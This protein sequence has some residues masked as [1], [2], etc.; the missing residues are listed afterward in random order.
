MKAGIGVDSRASQRHT[1]V[2]C[3]HGRDTPDLLDR[4]QMLR[5]CARADFVEKH[6]EVVEPG[7]R[8]G[9]D[10]AGRDSVDMN[11]ASRE[12]GCQITHARF[13][14]GLDRTH[15]VVIVDRPFGA[16]ESH[17]HQAAAVVHQRHR[18]LRHAD[19]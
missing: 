16:V 14:R 3:E 15:Q 8:T 4:D 11:L 17:G 12:I 19:E 9:L 18:Q 13:E 5:R 1:G 10:R 7:R 6:V 2:A